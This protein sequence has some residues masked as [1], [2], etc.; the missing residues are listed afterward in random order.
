MTSANAVQRVF[1]SAGTSVVTL[2]GT[3][4]KGVLSHSAGSSIFGPLNASHRLGVEVLAGRGWALGRLAPS[5]RALDS[6]AASVRLF[7]EGPGQR[8]QG[9]GEQLGTFGAIVSNIT[10]C[11]PKVLVLAAS[12]AALAS[13]VWM[14]SREKP[15]EV[16]QEDLNSGVTVGGLPDSGVHEHDLPTSLQGGSKKHPTESSALG[17]EPLEKFMP[18]L[19]GDWV[20]R[21]H[22]EYSAFSPPAINNHVCSTRYSTAKLSVSGDRA[23]MTEQLQLVEQGSKGLVKSRLETPIEQDSY[24]KERQLTLQITEQD[25]VVQVVSAP[26]EETIGFQKSPKDAQPAEF[27]DV[28]DR[29]EERVDPVSHKK[30]GYLASAQVQF[31]GVKVKGRVRT[32]QILRGSLT[33]AVQNPNFIQG[34]LDLDYRQAV[35]FS[36]NARIRDA[37]PKDRFMGENSDWVAVRRPADWGPTWPQGRSRE[38]RVADLRQLFADVPLKPGAEEV[39]Q[40]GWGLDLN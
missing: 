3:L 33:G 25:G 9:L 26:Y 18:A 24:P 8:L 36:D 12:G 32:M 14:R 35:S 29:R 28:G 6:P 20:I 23:F 13:L 21:Q 34:D 38:E 16:S 1:S 19:A 22:R 27:P 11:E 2:S 7:S 30:L 37:T 31:L 39:G 4:L 15:S 40:K 10:K 17:S 5:L